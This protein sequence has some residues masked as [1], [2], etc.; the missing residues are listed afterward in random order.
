MK[1]GCYPYAA[2]DEMPS[3]T[4]PSCPSIDVMQ[5]NPYG[6][7]VSAHPC[8]SGS[9]DAVSQCKYDMMVEGE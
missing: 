6:F 1:A 3:G 8:A 5:A 2:M 4:M 7:N 9:C